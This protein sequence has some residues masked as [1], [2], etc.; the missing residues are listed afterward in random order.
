[1]T[2]KLK[3]PADEALDGY[4]YDEPMENDID[5]S[6]YERREFQITPLLATLLPQS[7]QDIQVRYLFNLILIA[8]VLLY[9]FYS[10]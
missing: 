1:M 7:S 4:R 2:F 8:S 3:V 9:V 5:S 10:L 6:E